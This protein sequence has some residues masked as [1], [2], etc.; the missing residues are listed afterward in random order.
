MLSEINM[1]NQNSATDNQKLQIMGKRN[2]NK[3]TINVFALMNNLG[4][5]KDIVNV[6]GKNIEMLTSSLIY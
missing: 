2:E 3:Y 4:F 6:N 1:E 5:D